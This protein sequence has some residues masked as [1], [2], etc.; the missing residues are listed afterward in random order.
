M[1]SLCESCS[2]VHRL[3]LKI[4]GYKHFFFLSYKGSI[5]CQLQNTHRY[6]HFP[7]SPSLRGMVDVG[8]TKMCCSRLLFTCLR[9]SKQVR[10]LI[11]LKPLTYDS[12]AATSEHF[13]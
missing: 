8:A 10:S 11:S 7:A 5:L 4:C 9:N 12:E 1:C 13:C 3:L 6:R 2:T